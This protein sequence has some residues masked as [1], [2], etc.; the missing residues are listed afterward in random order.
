MNASHAQP[1]APLLLTPLGRGVHGT[2]MARRQN[3][4]VEEQVSYYTITEEAKITK[5]LY[6][7]Y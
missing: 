2:A 7:K 1:A 6:V 4:A 3:G 5:M